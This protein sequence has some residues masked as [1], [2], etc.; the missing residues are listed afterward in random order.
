LQVY[1]KPTF[2]AWVR[3]LEQVGLSLEDE[4]HRERDPL[5]PL[6]WG[7]IASSWPHERLLKDLSRSA[8]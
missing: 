1:R 7:H 2:R 4:V 8:R 6:P 5:E 3:A